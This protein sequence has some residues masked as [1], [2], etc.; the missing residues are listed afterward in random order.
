MPLPATDFPPECATLYP[1]GFRYPIEYLPSQDRV[2]EPALLQTFAAWLRPYVIRYND[3]IMVSGQA[4][5]AVRRLQRARRD[6]NLSSAFRHLEWGTTVEDP[7]MRASFNAED[8][9]SEARDWSDAGHHLAAIALLRSLPVP[10]QQTHT[11]L[12]SLVRSLKALER[13]E[14]ALIE[15]ERLV[16]V[17]DI[18]DHARELYHIEQAEL[19][20]HLDRREQAAALL[21]QWQDRLRVHWSYYGMRAALALSEG[22]EDVAKMF[23]LKAGHV[24]DFHCYKMLWNR[25]LAS[26]ETFIRTELLTEDNKPRLYERDK[27]MQ[28]LCHSIH[29]AFVSGDVMAASSLAQALQFRHIH[30]WQCTESLALALLGLGAWNEITKVMPILP[31]YQMGTIQAVMA[32]ARRILGQQ[33]GEEELLANLEE[34]HSLPEPTRDELHALLEWHN[35]GRASPLPPRGEV[36]LADIAPKNWGEAGRDHWLLV[37]H[38]EYGFVKR[39]FF[40]DR[41]IR[42]PEGWTVQELYPVLEE[43]ILSMEDAEAWLEKLLAEN[44]AER[45]NFIPYRWT[46]HW[47]GWQ[48]PKCFRPC[49]D[50][51]LLSETLRLSL[52]DPNFHFHNGPENTFGLRSQFGEKLV[53]MLRCGLI[54]A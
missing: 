9:V 12:L 37:S 43:T 53:W 30:N 41:S 22:Q 26:L 28:R 15:S 42:R 47:N 27:E 34:G 2:T 14:E 29:G 1:E 16:R 39:R 13:H 10:F 31:G 6:D 33:S 36:I 54:Q 4:P 8:T 19:L 20:L 48:L 3:E 24:D 35:A 45:G 25:H 52:A 7:S 32:L 50:L 23:V 46:V 51:P 21:D 49:C 11:A 38:P 40:Q 5:P 18:T 17:E 44:R